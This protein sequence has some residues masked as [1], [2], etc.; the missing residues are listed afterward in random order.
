MSFLARFAPQKGTGA[1]SRRNREQIEGSCF[2]AN[3]KRHLVASAESNTHPVP[4]GRGGRISTTRRRSTPTTRSAQ[5]T[6]AATGTQTG[7]GGRGSRAVPGEKSIF[8][9]FLSRP[10]RLR[11]RVRGATAAIFIGAAAFRCRLCRAPRPFVVLLATT[12]RLGCSTGGDAAALRTLLPHF[13][14]KTTHRIPC[15]ELCGTGYV[16]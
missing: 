13:P 2:R 14:R 1:G 12:P 10:S 6:Q 5:R 16:E 9:G 4:Y 8:G 3:K 11:G 7:E 15:S